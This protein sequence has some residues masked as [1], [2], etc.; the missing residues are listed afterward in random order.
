MVESLAEQLT[1]AEAADAELAPAA[2]SIKAGGGVSYAD[3]FAIATA[4]RHAVPLLSGDPEILVLD[5]PGL[6][7]V[8]LTSAASDERDHG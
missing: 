6:R 1:T 2:A 4:E 3:S 8:D 5:R 7:V